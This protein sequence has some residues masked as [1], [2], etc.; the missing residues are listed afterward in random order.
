MP[1]SLP[2][3]RRSSHSSSHH[4][5]PGLSPAWLELLLEEARQMRSELPL[6][7]QALAAKVGPAVVALSKG[8]TRD[9]ALLGSRYLDARDV[10]VAYLLYFVPIN[11]ARSQ[12]LLRLALEP[13]QQRL[14]EERLQ[15]G[16]TPTEHVLRVTDLGC[17]PGTQLLALLTVL[18]EMQKKVQNSVQ[19]EGASAPGLPK[20][21]LIYRAVDHSP[22][23]LERLASLLKRAR[24]KGLIP[25][26]LTLELSCVRAGLEQKEA[27]PTEKQSLFLMGYSL[28]E[29]TAQSTAVDTV[30]ASQ[31][32]ESYVAELGGWLEPDGHLLMLEPALQETAFVLQTLRDLLVTGGWRVV[33]PCTHTAPCPLNGPNRPPRQ[34]CHQELHW[35]RPPLI[36]ALD[37]VTGLDKEH[38]AFSHL[39]LQPA[40]LADTSSPSTVST[41]SRGRAYRAMS[42]SLHARGTVS[43]YLCG[44]EG[45]RE[46][47]L[48]TRHLNPT[49]DAFTS[50][51]RGDTVFLGTCGEKGGKLRIE[52]DT[53]VE[54]EPG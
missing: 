35:E 32:A 15:A 51:G 4:P 30:G 12:R 8:L 39:L 9:R 16:G 53:D 38:P 48:L 36:A 47:M 21:R 50:V 33:S 44:E 3:S 52:A 5:P 34:W 24:K 29:L 17:G 46:A 49:T 43:V 20:I 13:F 1:K 7:P 10:G 25:P 40:P 27:L 22:S 19:M 28:N 6:E 45:F 14:S 23:A 26:S 42:P 11:A 18:I 41:V 31:V 54:V 37:R 2:L